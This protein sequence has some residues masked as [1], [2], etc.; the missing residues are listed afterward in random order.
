MPKFNPHPRPPWSGFAADVLE[1]LHET[2][3]I[4]SWERPRNDAFASPVVL[5]GVALSPLQ[6]KRGSECALGAIALDELA[7]PP[8]PPHVVQLCLRLAAHFGTAD[9][10]QK[11]LQPGQITMIGGI[12]QDQLSFVRE[13]IC[14]GFAP[15][16]LRIGFAPR[17][18]A[19]CDVM[20][21]SPEDGL[22]STAAASFHRR[23]S[24]ALGHSQPLILLCTDETEPAAELSRYLPP[25]A[26]LAP[27][28]REVLFELLRITWPK[29]AAGLVKIADQFPD[30]H[31]LAAL[32]LPAL[33]I[34][35]RA[36]S[37]FEVAETLRNFLAAP[38]V[39]KG[40]QLSDIHGG[41]PA[42]E[43]AKRIVADLQSWRDGSLPWAE[44]SRSLLL[45]GR[46]G[47]GKTWLA[48]A[49]GNSPGVGFVAASFA[50]WQARGHLGDML[51]AMQ[52]SFSEARRLAPAILFIDEI[53]AVG[54]RGGRDR[55]ADYRHQ[56]VN[57]FLQAM[58][59]IAR[60]EGVIVVGA[61]N[62]PSRI[63]PAVLRAGRF[64]LKAEVKLPCHDAIQGILTAHLG[65]IL[66]QAEISE[67]ARAAIGS[68]AAEID[69][70]I[71]GAKAEARAWGTNLQLAELRKLLVGDMPASPELDHRLA[72]HE[73]GHA[74]VGHELGFSVLRAVLTRG[75]GVTEHA[76]PTNAGRLQDIEAEIIMCMAGRAAEQMVF[77]DVSGG[78]GGPGRSD[79]ARATSLAVAIDTRLGLGVFGPIWTDCS[80]HAVMRDPDARQRVRVRLESAEQQ[81][82]RILQTNR[83]HF[84]GMAA[85]LMRERDLTGDTLQTWLDKWKPPSPYSAP[86]PSETR[87]ISD[88]AHPSQLSDCEASNAP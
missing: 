1:R 53:D 25:V 66:H 23:I 43:A 59:G 87:L 84:D 52:A 27:L 85:A 50:D 32:P 39:K 31:Q 71:R 45:H 46:P 73:C 55:N 10:F 80:L 86:A 70:A 7:L 81:A 68:T 26:R 5:P 64:D 49:M 60:E 6:N 11:C 24:A 58:D 17:H 40:P 44:M 79:L 12:G 20:V 63:D 47:T 88:I 41:G 19:E 35:L 33:Q 14:L 3:H 67:L 74:I 22:T 9:G 38:E 69:A 34:A 37:A 13:L 21:L 28:N 56:V 42:L 76:V 61:C 30:D 65:Q 36:N 72:V 83:P 82:S 77:S 75:G 8:V 18:H 16:N 78:S 29:G 57:G 48:R 51:K 62:D 54:A 4:H 15:E 2:W